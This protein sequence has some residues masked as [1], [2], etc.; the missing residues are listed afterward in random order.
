MSERIPA[1]KLIHPDDEF[2]DEIIEGI[3]KKL[4]ERQVNDLPDPYQKYTVKEVAKKLFVT[5]WTVQ[6]YIRQ[7]RLA[8]HVPEGKRKYVIFHKDLEAFINSKYEKHEQ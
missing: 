6:K 4:K 2:L 3:E 7:G 8:G 1:S 5:V